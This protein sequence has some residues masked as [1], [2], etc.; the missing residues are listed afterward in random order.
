[1]LF[2]AAEDYPFDAKDYALDEDYA[3]GEMEPS[4]PNM[5]DDGFVAGLVFPLASVA[6]IFPFFIVGILLS[7]SARYLGI[8]RLLSFLIL[9]VSFAPSVFHAQYV[10]ESIFRVINGPPIAKIERLRI[11]VATFASTSLLYTLAVF[12]LGAF[13]IW[14]VPWTVVLAPLV[15]STVYVFFLFQPLRAALAGTGVIIDNLALGWLWVEAILLTFGVLGWLLGRYIVA[16]LR[17]R[18]EQKSFR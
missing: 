17:Y 15:Y 6:V 11:A 10:R 14:H 13:L 12:L 16:S 18:L 2:D 7:L 1:M 5:V 8:R 4:G 9:L 3:V